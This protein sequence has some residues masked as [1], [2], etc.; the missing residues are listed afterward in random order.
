MKKYAL[1]WEY[2]LSPKRLGSASHVP[3]SPERSQ[4]QRDYDRIIFSSPFRRLQN[5]TQVFPLPGSIF[6]H[7]R[8]THSLEVASV[9]RSLGNFLAVELEKNGQAAGDDFF[10]SFGAIVSAACLAHDLGNPPFGHSGEKAISRYFS[11]GNGK[12]L[13]KMVSHDEWLDLTHFEGNAN[14]FRVLTHRFQGRRNGGFALTYAT[15]ASLVKYPYGSAAAGEKHKYGFFASEKAIFSEIAAEQRLRC[16]SGAGVYSRH[17]LVYLVEAADDITYQI[18]DVEDAHKLKILSYDE[19]YHILTSFWEAA[20]E[21]GK[22][23]FSYTDEIFKTVT[24]RNERIS[25][26]RATLINKLVT[27]CI[28]LFI[29][30]Y[31]AI[32]NGCFDRSLMDALEGISAAGMENCRKLSGKRIYNH[33]SVVEVEIAGY[34]I[35]GA[36]LDDF[37]DAALFP[38]S[39]YA[40]KLLLLLP[41][42]FRSQPDDPV[43]TQIQSVLDFVSGMTDLFA[44]DLYR[45][46]HGMKQG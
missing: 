41:E 37:V 34:R 25:Y 16:L 46:I 20:S 43:Y 4:F 2:L 3:K 8:L 24:D 21:E 5:K 32:M 40:Q 17:P 15:L 42:Q 45:T 12:A 39:P 44:L 19:T 22:A 13:Q 30:H 38:Q 1:E 11:D 7:N 10:S 23:F 35:L 29:R 31:E 28:D 9:G 6:V 14:A 33:P 26:L 36:L 18:M 27:E